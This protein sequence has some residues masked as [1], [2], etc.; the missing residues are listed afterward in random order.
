[1]A[2]TNKIKFDLTAGFLCRDRVKQDLENSKAKLKHWYPECH[3]LLTENK[4]WF[5]TTFYFEAYNIPEE[6]EPALRKWKKQ[7]EN[8]V[9]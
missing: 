7:I 3:V 8:L 6:A 2:A 4:D 5:D 1:M 9:G